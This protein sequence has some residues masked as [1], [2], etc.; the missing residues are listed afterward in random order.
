MYRVIVP[1]FDLSDNNHK[2]EVGDE[3]PRKGYETSAKRV[4]EL[5]SASNRRGIPLIE[6]ETS[7][8][9]EEK[10]PTKKAK[11]KK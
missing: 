11:A 5:A 6:A 1:F 4:V 8:E 2:Y 7:A 9:E 3:Y 10:K